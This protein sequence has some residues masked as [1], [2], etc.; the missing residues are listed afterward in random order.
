MLYVLGS[1][2]FQQGL[3]ATRLELIPDSGKSPVTHGVI[4]PE[5]AIP[6]ADYQQDLEN[7][8]ADWAIDE[9]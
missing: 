5:Q 1:G 3:I 7:T 9:T 2:P 8:R 4:A 6:L